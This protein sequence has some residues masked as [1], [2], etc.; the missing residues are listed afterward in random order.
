LARLDKRH[1][2]SLVQRFFA[3]I[4]HQV[5][6]LSTDEEVGDDLLTEVAPSMSHSYILDFSDDT[7][8]TSARCLAEEYSA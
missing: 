5:M 8:S 1:R 3:K 2:R 4:S 7:R 6:V